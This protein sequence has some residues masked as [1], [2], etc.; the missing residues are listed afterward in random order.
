MSKVG[1]VE[2]IATLSTRQVADKVG[3]STSWVRSKHRELGGCKVLIDGTWSWRFPDTAIGLALALLESK[4][5]TIVAVCPHCGHESVQV[6][7]RGR[8]VKVEQEPL[9][10]CEEVHL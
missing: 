9:F 6:A 5:T 2:V 3:M 1:G 10:D 4:K 8:T 7:G